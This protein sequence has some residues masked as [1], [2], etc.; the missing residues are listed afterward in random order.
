[1]ATLGIYGV[2]SYAVRQ[3]TVE[4]GTRMALG[5]VGGDLVTLVVGDGLKLAATGLAFGA[6]AI[7]GGVWVLISLL[8][9]QNVGWAPVVFSTAIVAGIAMVASWVPAWR[10]TLLS[11]MVAIRD[12]QA[13]VWQSAQRGLRRAMRSVAQ[14]VNRDEGPA[15]IRTDALA[16]FVAASRAAGSFADALQTVLG[17]VCDVLT[18]ESGLLLEKKVDGGY[19]SAVAVGALA[20]S[21]LVIA[22]DGYLIGRLMAYSQPLPFEPGEFEALAAWADASR[23][24]RAAEI[25]RLAGASVRLVVPLR[26]HNDIIGVLLFGAPSGREH[27]TAGEKEFLRNCAD[28]FALM[29]ENAR[30]TERV[31]E[32]ETLRRDLALAAEIQR[33]LLPTESPVADV[34]EFAALSIPARSIGG[35]YHDF[36]RTGDQIGVAVADVSGKGVAA[37]LIMAVMQASLRIFTAE[38]GE[39]LPRMVARINRSLFRSTPANKYATFFYAQVDPGSRQLR[40]VNAGHNPPYLIR[41]GRPPGDADIQELAAGGTVVGMFPEMAYE[42]ST[43]DLCPGDVLL[44]FTDGVTEAH[45]PESVEFGE[46]QLKAVLARV[47]HLPADQICATIAAELKHWIQDAEQYD[48]LTLVVMKVR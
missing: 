5:A 17:K 32:Q 4:M 35:D 3:R 33:G 12:Q 34:A 20:S 1:M 9:V 28:Q 25:R 21:P 42:E 15:T 24:E 14:V 48:D 40:Y 45:S 26:T 29:L 38:S 19:H 43:V 44:A 46:D 6:I 27:F 18:V 37:A 31:V 36:I 2:V 8:D 23:P 7:V 41:G 30:L 10:T 22:V 39:P 16:E 47:A 13:S 11:P